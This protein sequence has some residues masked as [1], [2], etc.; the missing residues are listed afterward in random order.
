MAACGLHGSDFVLRFT[1]ARWRLGQATPNARRG[2]CPQVAAI[3]YEVRPRRAGASGTSPA[4][5][6][7]HAGALF[8][9]GFSLLHA[10]LRYALDGRRA[11]GG[12]CRHG[13]PTP[14]VG[15]RGGPRCPSCGSPARSARTPGRRRGLRESGV[16]LRRAFL[17]AAAGW[18]QWRV[19]LSAHAGGIRGVLGGA[20]G[21]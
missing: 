18:F 9:R 21:T 19:G 2:Q 12:R 10:R 5:P 11:N 3:P 17:S 20:V 4:T 16:R 7:A 13:A 14:H 1:F 15:G 6:W 8:L